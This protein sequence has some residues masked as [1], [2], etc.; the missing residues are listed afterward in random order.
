MSNNSRAYKSRKFDARWLCLAMFV[1]IAWTAFQGQTQARQDSSTIVSQ[2]N[3]RDLNRVVQFNPALL[4]TPQL[5]S[6]HNATIAEAHRLLLEGSSDCTNNCSPFHDIQV[7]LPLFTSSDEEVALLPNRKNC[8]VYA[9]GVGTNEEKA[10]LGAWEEKMTNTCPEVHVFDC[11]VSKFPNS[12][13]KKKRFTFHALCVENVNSNKSLAS[14]MKQFGHSNLDILKV[15]IQSKDWGTL[16]LGAQLESI[17][18][19]QVVLQLYAGSATA[20]AGADSARQAI[21]K[22]LLQMYDIGYR[23]SGIKQVK[24]MAQISLVAVKEPARKK[25]TVL[26]DHA[27]DCPDELSIC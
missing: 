16:D 22:I 9:V 10:R 12:V 14:T 2:T 27:G 6:Q 17:M 21:N 13:L 5:V 20:S 1:V 23:V 11:K 19:P 8:V 7:A 25:D 4:V 18:P 3:R 15:Y 26:Y 24:D